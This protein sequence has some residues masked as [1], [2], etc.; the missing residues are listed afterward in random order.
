M[1]QTDEWK[2]LYPSDLIHRKIMHV[3]NIIN[4]MHKI[5]LSACESSRNP[6]ANPSRMV[7]GRHPTNRN[8]SSISPVI[9][10]FICYCCSYSLA[11][12]NQT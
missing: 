3:L 5:Y 2:Q 8:P 1:G 4:R 9:N 10:I 7:K 6:N 11:Q 12:Y